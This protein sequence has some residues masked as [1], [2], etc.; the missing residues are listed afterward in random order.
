[1]RNLLLFILI[2]IVVWWVRRALQRP[3]GLF[4]ALR[5]RA[6]GEQPGKRTGD[7]ERM[8]ACAHC[9]VHV[10][11]SECVRDADA[12][13]CCADHRRLGVRR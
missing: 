2:L 3:G 5:G 7:P 6:S 1:M 4:G 9:G 13:Y 8:V 12:A 11:E 10:P